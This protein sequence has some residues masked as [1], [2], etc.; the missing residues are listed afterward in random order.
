MDC[1]GQIELALLRA[2]ESNDLTVVT[3][4]VKQGANVNKRGPTNLTPLMV[5]AGRG[6]VQMTQL[7]LDAGADVYTIDSVT[8]ASPLHKAAQSGV[9]DVA[10]L[11]LNHGAF[12]NL[13]SAIVGHTPLMD[14]VWSKKPPMVKFLL[15]QGAI[16]DI[17]GHH[18]ADVWEFVSDQP[19]WTAGFTTPRKEKWGQQIYAYLKARQKADEEALKQPLMEAVTNG[20]LD[21]VKCLIGEGV[22]VNEPSPIVGDGNDGQNPLLVACFLGHSQIVVE[23]LEAGANPHIV[24]YLM[25]ATPCHKGAYAGQS[26]A[27]KA[28]IKNSN[29]QVN[30]QGP[31][32]GYSALHDATWHGHKE[33]VEVLLD[34]NV[35]TTLQGHDGKTPVELAREFGYKDIEK[36]IQNKISISE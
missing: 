29:V 9:I 12:L 34:A 23:L 16:I 18:G 22:D 10:K 30:A 31:Y 6:Y 21:K 14:A 2:V 5:A 36:L 15:D 1:N 27:L 13:Q 19:T 3:D 7:L 20:D 25:K 11:L 24:D 35:C 17:K 32:N 33:A 4:L 26:T 28:L 8:G